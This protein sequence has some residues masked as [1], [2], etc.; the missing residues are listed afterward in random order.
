MVEAPAEP[1]ADGQVVG[2]T[3]S[4]GRGE[5]LQEFPLLPLKTVRAAGEV[6]GQSLC[7]ASV[8]PSCLYEM[9]TGIK[10]NLSASVASARIGHQS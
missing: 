6:A 4:D 3:S 5:P 8:L 10:L 9:R 2:Q 7:H 1:S